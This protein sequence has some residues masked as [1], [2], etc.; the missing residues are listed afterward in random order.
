MGFRTAIEFCERWLGRWHLLEWLYGKRREFVGAAM[1]IGAAALPFWDEIRQ[2]NPAWI[3]LILAAAFALVMVGINQ[4]LRFFD[5]W[6]RSERTT[7]STGRGRGVA[8]L[9]AAL[10]ARDAESKIKEADQVIMSTYKKLLEGPYPDEAAWARDYT[11]WETAMNRIDSLV[12]Q[13]AAQ[14][15]KPFIDLEDLKLGAPP[16]PLQCNIKSAANVMRYSTVWHGQR[17]YSNRREEVLRF[18]ASKSR[19]LPE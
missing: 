2:L 8:M 14:P 13:W 16:A 18:F 9:T 5:W 4:G 1:T 6:R 11:T 7:E 17:S 12:P 10:R 3:I 19:E 15:H